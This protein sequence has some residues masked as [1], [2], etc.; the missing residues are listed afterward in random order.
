MLVFHLLHTLLYPCSCTLSLCLAQSFLSCQSLLLVED[1]SHLSLVLVLVL[2]LETQ[3]KALPIKSAALVS[4][5]HYSQL[6]P[7]I[8]YSYFS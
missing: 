8:G 1:L 7:S 5:C 4:P 3:N 6:H 2:V